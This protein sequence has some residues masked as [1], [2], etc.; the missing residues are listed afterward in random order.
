MDHLDPF[1]EVRAL[2]RDLY[3]QFGPSKAMG[4]AATATRVPHFFLLRRMFGENDL[5]IILNT[6]RCRYQCDFCELPSKSS[7]ALISAIDIAIQIQSVLSECKHALSMLDRITLSNEGS[8]LDSTTLP[9]GALAAVFGA[10]SELKPLKRVV[11]ESRLEFVR[12]DYLARLNS[13]APRVRLDVLTGFETLDERVRDEIL[14][15]REPLALFLRGLDLVGRIPGA[16]VT[17]YVLMKPEPGMTDEKGVE[18]AI[19]TIAFLAEE[20]QSRG[21][22]LAIRLNPMYVARGSR[23]ADLA[24]AR[25]YRP[26]RLTDVLAVARVAAG[27]G[28]PTH[29]GLSAE[30]LA[31]DLGT[32]RARDDFSRELLKEAIEFNSAQKWPRA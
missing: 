18:E 21:L 15:K 30:G 19:R 4:V 5:L 3:L 7:R 14:N 2:A 11:L 32:Y 28:I 1:P 26:P 24:A 20:S 6:K 16:S 10:A 9:E 17:C 31:G 13:V 29:V 25:G 22:P 12:P 8:V 23:W 27:R